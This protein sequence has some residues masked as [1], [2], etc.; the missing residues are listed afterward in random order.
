MKSVRIRSYSGPHFPACGL[1]TER[2]SVSFRI[3][4]EC[5][6]MRT[7]ITLNTVTFYAVIHTKSVL[8]H[9]I[10]H[11]IDVFNCYTKVNTV[12]LCYLTLYRKDSSFAVSPILHIQLYYSQLF[13]YTSCFRCL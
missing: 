8:F 10:G 5:G 6:K 11:Y 2:Y 1:N 3:R 13:K 4:S 7:R 9:K 12:D